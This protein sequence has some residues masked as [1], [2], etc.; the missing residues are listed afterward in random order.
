MYQRYCE[1]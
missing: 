1:G